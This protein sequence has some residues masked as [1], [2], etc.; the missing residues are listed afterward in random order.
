ML[1]AAPGDVADGVAGLHLA[2]NKSTLMMSPTDEQGP[3][4]VSTLD[5]VRRYHSAG[6][7]APAHASRVESTDFQRCGRRRARIYNHILMFNK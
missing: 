4:V 3:V 2:G 6:R 1:F 5:R 7:V